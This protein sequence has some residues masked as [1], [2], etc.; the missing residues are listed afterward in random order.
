[1]EYVQQAFLM[2]DT[3][4]QLCD[5]YKFGLHPVKQAPPRSSQAHGDSYVVWGLWGKVSGNREPGGC[6]VHKVYV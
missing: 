1:M 6:C 2:H 5:N 4:I 3:M